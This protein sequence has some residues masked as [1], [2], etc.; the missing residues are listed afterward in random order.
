[1]I[2]RGLD[3]KLGSGCLILEAIRRGTGDNNLFGPKDSLINN[4]FKEFT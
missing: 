4:E 3:L 1:M 2:E